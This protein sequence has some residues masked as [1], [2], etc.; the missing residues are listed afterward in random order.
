MDPSIRPTARVRPS[1]ANAR[2]RYSSPRSLLDD[3]FIPR[4]MGPECQG[5]EPHRDEHPA[6][7]RE[8]R[9]D[10]RR[11]M[12]QRRNQVCLGCVLRSPLAS[13]RPQDDH[14]VEA[15]RRQGLAVGSEGQRFNITVVLAQFEHGRVRCGVGI[16]FSG[17]QPDQ[18]SHQGQASHKPAVQEREPGP[19]ETSVRHG[20]IDSIPSRTRV[21]RG[22]TCP[23]TSC[24]S[25]RRT[26]KLLESGCEVRARTPT[27][28]IDRIGGA[29]IDDKHRGDPPPRVRTARTMPSRRN[30]CRPRQPTGGAASPIRSVP[31]PLL[32]NPVPGCEDPSPWETSL[33]VYY[34]L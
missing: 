19:T 17:K 29:S 13:D 3:L 1:G 16:R 8:R 22:A 31:D 4:T 15:A 28:P 26:W 21:A 33:E 7:G 11:G 2:H 32:R 25:S 5:I 10:D 6:V 23:S 34:K 9:V 18:S 20:E 12:R 24:R 30:S 14:R 27:G